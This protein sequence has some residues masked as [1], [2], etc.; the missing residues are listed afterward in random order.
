MDPGTSHNYIDSNY[1][2]QLGLPLCHVGKMSIITAGTKHLTSKR[3]QLWLDRK[4]QGEMWNYAA[5]TG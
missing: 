3:Y 5:I 2:R 1:T 4:V